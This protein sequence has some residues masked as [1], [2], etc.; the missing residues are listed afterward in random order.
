SDFGLS[1]IN[2]SSGNT[3]SSSSSSPHTTRS[4]GDPP[5]AFS[6]NKSPLTEIQ[7]IHPLYVSLP[8]PFPHLHYSSPAAS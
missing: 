5:L 2:P 8:F 6:L 4:F 1:P 3:N 7:G